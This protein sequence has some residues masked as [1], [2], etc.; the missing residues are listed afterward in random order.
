MKKRF[1]AIFVVA[2]LLFVPL[3]LLVANRYSGKCGSIWDSPTVSHCEPIPSPG[4][5]PLV[6]RTCDE[7]LTPPGKENGFLSVPRSFPVHVLSGS[8][9]IISVLFI[10]SA[11]LNSACH[12]SK[13]KDG[14]EPSTPV[15]QKNAKYQVSAKSLVLIFVLGI[16]S[17]VYQGFS[18]LLIIHKCKPGPKER[19]AEV[20]CL[21]SGSIEVVLQGE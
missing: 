11:W 8:L 7:S 21:L 12:S 3:F 5:P 2:L 20:F 15:F 10:F 9:H 14:D 17:L 19:A 13:E 6:W 4:H 16:I 1:I 18:F